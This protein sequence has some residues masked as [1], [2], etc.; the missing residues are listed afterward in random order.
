MHLENFHRYNVT[1]TSGLG[2]LKWSCDAPLSFFFDPAKVVTNGEFGDSRLRKQLSIA[3]HVD[4]MDV[5][6]S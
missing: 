2:R 1:D 5:K 4:I 3:L 6:G